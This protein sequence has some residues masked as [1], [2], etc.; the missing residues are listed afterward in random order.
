MSL[1]KGNIIYLVLIGILF[2]GTA[3]LLSTTVIDIVKQR[4]MISRDVDRISGNYLRQPS[5]EEVTRNIERRESDVNEIADKFFSKI[6]DEF[7]FVKFL[8]NL[9]G[10]DIE[11]KIKFDINGKIEEG[12]HTKA[13]LEITAIADYPAVFDYLNK[14]EK[15]KYFFEIDSIDMLNLKPSSAGAS[16]VQATISGFVYWL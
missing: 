5:L 10:P 7:E 11:Q 8:E 15:L 9:G 12:G 3:F 1:S 6:D 13:P 16:S 2:A 14:L 4:E